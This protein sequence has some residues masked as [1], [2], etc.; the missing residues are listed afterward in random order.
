MF[1]FKGKTVHASV[2]VRREVGAQS[3]SLCKGIRP[4]VLR[5]Q[6][7]AFCHLNKL[8]DWNLRYLFCTNAH[9]SKS[10]RAII[11]EIGAITVLSFT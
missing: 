2:L 5:S 6:Q 1:H 9:S 3:L 10:I 7:P 11:A 4:F 8:V